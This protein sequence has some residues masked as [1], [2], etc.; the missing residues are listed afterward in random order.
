MVTKRVSKATSVVSVSIQDR[1]AVLEKIW[2]WHVT[3]PGK[4]LL[5]R[6]RIP[7][8]GY[9]EIGSNNWAADV[10]QKAIDEGWTV[11]DLNANN[12]T[13]ENIEASITDDRPD[14]IIHYDH[15][16]TFTM[17]GQESNALE[18]GLDELNI[19]LAT[20]R[21]VSTVSCYTAAGLGPAAIGD[22]VVAY[23]G[24][25]EPHAFWTGFE[26]DFGPA[27][28]AA[29]YALLECKTVQESFDIGWAAYDALYV[30]LLGRGGFAATHVAPTALHDRDCFA[31]LGSS[32]AVACPRSLTVHCYAIPDN[33]VPCRYGIPR[34]TVCKGLPIFRCNAGLPDSVISICAAMPDLNMCA[35]GPPLRIREIIED[36]PR[37]LMLVD[38][39]KIPQDMRKAF[40][41]MME[42]M[43]SEK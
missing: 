3:R 31:M 17:W 27:A 11:I 5:I 13:R 29:N 10:K 37:D 12:A 30:D 14:L 1:L 9:T 43:G 32:T 21:I 36:Y 15:G 28:N 22:G 40:T 7:G 20:G 2:H 35:A 34:M 42:R 26:N 23:L 6:P 8:D 39:D 4:L 41:Q 33:V 16:S 24:Y 19:G 38:I 25:T 18:A